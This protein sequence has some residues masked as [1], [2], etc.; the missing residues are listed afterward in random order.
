MST[1]GEVK[2]ALQYALSLGRG[3]GLSQALDI[4]YAHL[5]DDGDELV[6]KAKQHRLAAL[7]AEIAKLEAERDALQTP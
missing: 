1:K 3:A 2:E 5:D 6:A 7:N 4:V